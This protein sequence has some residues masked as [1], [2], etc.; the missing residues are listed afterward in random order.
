IWQTR[1]LP[2]L[3]IL[4]AAR[5][6]SIIEKRRALSALQVAICFGWLLATLRLRE[7]RGRKHGRISQINF[8]GAIDLVKPMMRGFQHLQSIEPTESQPVP[9]PE[10]SCG[11]LSRESAPTS[12]E[13]RPSC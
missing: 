9:P 8:R 7:R 10:I 4:L 13:S 2:W 5:N 12:R 1:S 3:E 6:G 11:Y